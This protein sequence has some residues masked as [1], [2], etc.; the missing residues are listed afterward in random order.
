MFKLIKIIA[1]L[2]LLPITAIAEPVN[3]ATSTLI[4][5]KGEIVYSGPLL[6]DNGKP[7]PNSA[8][9]HVVMKNTSTIA[10]SGGKLKRAIYFCKV[11]APDLSTDGTTKCYRVSE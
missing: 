4:M 5:R 3:D 8:F 9:Y 11:I 6:A 10:S 7:I 2:F 1:V